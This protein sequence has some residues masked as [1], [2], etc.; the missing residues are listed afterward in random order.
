M[1]IKPA[2][3]IPVGLGLWLGLGL[4]AIASDP[5]QPAPV[6]AQTSNPSLAVEALTYVSTTGRFAIN[7]PSSLETTTR[8]TTIPGD[9][10]AWTIST[11]RLDDSVYSVAYADMPLALLPLGKDAVLESLQTRPLL[12]DLDWAA[13]TEQG[14]PISLNDEVAGMEFLHL[15]EGR[16]STLRLYLANRRIYAVMGSSPDLASLNQVLASFAVDSLW[17][18]FTSES[19]RFSVNTPIAPVITTEQLSYQDTFL[20]WQEFTF[21]NLTAREDAYQVAYVDL[22]QNLQSMDVDTLLQGVADQLFT[23]AEASELAATG[24]PI[25]LNGATGREYLTTRAD[26]KSYILRL[27]RVDNRLYGVLAG[28]RSLDNLH[29][30]VNSFTVQ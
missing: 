5:L 13:I 20:S 1:M 27:Y 7:F 15:A 18:T 2:C 8:T 17:R 26:G 30:F 11:A 12:E 23:L 21:Y 3:W 25:R 4:P 16:Y 22:P 29:Q 6:L 9:L 28:S 14:R 24:T 10:L 19:G